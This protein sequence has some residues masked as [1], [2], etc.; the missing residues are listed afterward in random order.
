MSAKRG[1]NGFAIIKSSLHMSYSLIRKGK[2]FCLSSALKISDFCL[3][4]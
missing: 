3:I 1:L 4:V 2:Y